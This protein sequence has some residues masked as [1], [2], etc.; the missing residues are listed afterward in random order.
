MFD[1]NLYFFRRGTGAFAK[2]KQNQTDE[3][4]NSRYR[5]RET[6][7]R[8]NRLKN[9]S[10]LNNFNKNSNKNES[11]K[12]NSENLSNN[13]VNGIVTP[14]TIRE[15]KQKGLTKY[16][17]EMLIAQ[18]CKFSDIDQ[19]RRKSV[20]GRIGTASKG[21]DMCKEAEEKKSV[22]NNR[23]VKRKVEERVRVLRSQRRRSGEQV[24]SVMK[25][26]CNNL[27]PM[28]EETKIQVQ[29]VNDEHKN[30]NGDIIKESVKEDVKEV[31][32]KKIFKEEPELKRR[33]IYEFK[34]D[35]DSQMDIVK[36][37]AVEDSRINER[38]KEIKEE[39]IATS[40]ITTP[41]KG[42]LRL[43][44]RMKRSP[45]LDEVIESGSSLSGDSYN[46]H[47]EIC[48]VDGL[49]VPTSSEDSPT[50]SHRKKKHKKNKREH[51]RRRRKHSTPS[52]DRHIPYP[53]SPP[54]RVRLIF[55]NESHTIDIPQP[56]M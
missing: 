12:E 20:E 4:S 1:F 50:P 53:L 39:P 6:D 51:H 5:L 3:N 7:N 36:Q 13:K 45:I 40:P 56:V 41:S 48:R 54:K 46:R 30:F 35:I 28:E 16:D 47:Y 11:S 55:G 34:E 44:L 49:E 42:G 25:E 31:N 37:D 23:R 22:R 38:V 17:A 43:T 9:H 32:S 27:P 21:E 29:H 18:G 33:D 15:L 24:S 52:P 19:S 14:L 8:I 26:K 2:E 10:T